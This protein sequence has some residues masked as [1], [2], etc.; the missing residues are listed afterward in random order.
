MTKTNTLEVAVLQADLVWE[1]T[2]ENR[3]QFTKMIDSLSSEVE[4]I[5]LPE[6]FT[7]GFT[8]NAEKVAESMNGDTVLW[9]QNIAKTKQTAICGSVVIVERSFDSAQDDKFFN[10]LLFVHPSEKVEFYD[11]RHTFTLAGEHEVYSAGKKKLIVEYKGWKI[12][13]LICYDL[14]FPVWGRN[15]ENYDLLIY[16]ASW[17]KPRINAWSSL[18]KARA[19]ENM[20]YTI[21]V[22]R[23]G[24]DANNY[25]YNGNSAIYDCLGNTVNHFKKETTEP[26]L[27]TLDKN[28]QDKLRSRFSFLEDKDTFTIE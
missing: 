9:M 15:T 5:I 14:R 10:R 13:P 3:N 22:N 2:F 7:T 19:I 1:N 18:L 28:Y 21:G 4:L 27:F 6:M 16:V 25:E 11:K 23:V 24:K 26:S 17:P 20:S 8:M 12:S